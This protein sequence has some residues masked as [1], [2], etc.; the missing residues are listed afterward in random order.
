M[1]EIQDLVERAVAES[2]ADGCVVVAA[3][4]TEANL[5]WAGNSLTTNGQMHT[6]SMTV[7]ST[8]DGP[9]GTRAHGWLRFSCGDPLRGT[10]VHHWPEPGRRR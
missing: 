5:R 2:T 4:H 6:R 10:R 9:D 8:F 1:S 3:E 7:I